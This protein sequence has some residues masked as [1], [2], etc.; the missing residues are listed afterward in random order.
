MP[1]EFMGI[2]LEYFLDDPTG[3]S[4]H[5][6]EEYS[7]ETKAE[8]LIRFKKTLDEK[9]ENEINLD[10]IELEMK[11][12]N[13]I[14]KQNERFFDEFIEEQKILFAAPQ[15]NKTLTLPKK[16]TKV[17]PKIEKT[18]A[19]NTPTENDTES[20][21]GSQAQKDFQLL[22]G[23]FKNT[24]IA[25]L[26]PIEKLKQFLRML[27]YFHERSLEEILYIFLQEPRATE[28]NKSSQSFGLFSKNQPLVMLPSEPTEENGERLITYYRA[29]ISK[30]DLKKKVKNKEIFSY[31]IS[32]LITKT[33]NAVKNGVPNQKRFEY[34]SV[35]FAYGIRENT[36]QIFEKNNFFLDETDPKL[37]ELSLQNI[38][39]E[40]HLIQDSLAKKD[41]SNSNMN[42]TSQELLHKKL[43]DAEEE[44]NK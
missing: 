20:P 21:K 11:V 34:L 8:F 42:K 32:Q 24:A 5:F 33:T 30:N 39:N 19:K 40:I 38:L 2:L 26:L 31:L 12:F 29:T 16:E 17:P 6:L 4:P 36:L 10:Q 35:C 23:L 25:C 41:P 18:K 27:P 44:Q 13:F 7:K 14:K 22:N 1:T 28:L 43:D 9:Q 15:Q 37:L 3:T